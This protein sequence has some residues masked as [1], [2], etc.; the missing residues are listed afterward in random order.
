MDASVTAIIVDNGSSLLK[1][2]FGGEDAPRSAEPNVVGRTRHPGV[3]P[4]ILS[5]RLDVFAGCDAIEHEG[6][7]SLSYPVQ[8]GLVADWEML[9]SSLHYQL[10]RSL[11]VSCEE[12]PM[13]I[14]ECPDNPRVDREKLAHLLFES[15]NIPALCVGNT[16]AL[17]LYATGRTTGIVIDSG[18]SKTHIG[19]VWEGYCYQHFLQRIDFGGDG[20]TQQLAKQLRKEG[21]PFSTPADYRQA[22]R[23]KSELCYLA[24]NAEKELAY[25]KESRSLER[26]FSL[27][28]GQEIYLN[29]NRFMIPEVLFSPT[30]LECPVPTRGWHEIVQSCIEQCDPAVRSEMYGNV[31]LAGG[32]T[33]FP[34]LDERVQKEMSLLAPKGTV[35]KCVAFPN[36]QYGSWVGASIV[37]SMNTFPCMWVS[38]SEYDDYGAS[39][40]HRKC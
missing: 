8:R 39:I 38:K 26:M 9:E 20:V 21:Y 1:A 3:N 11:N 4:T 7:L 34:R 13:L 24:S 35:A 33:L 23:I 22:E 19:P 27:P 6:L 28:D 17:A 29:A 30:A 2:G 12:H 10:L 32:N 31:I 16:S 36:R 25:C 40:I 37:A 18:A 14:T 5:N 15:F